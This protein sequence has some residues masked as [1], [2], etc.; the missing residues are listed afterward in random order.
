MISAGCYFLAYLFEA[1]TVYMYFSNKFN[2]KIN[3]K[4]LFLAFSISLTIQYSASFIGN[5]QI[6]LVSFIVCSFLLCFLCYDTK[7]LSSIFNAVI[8]T[9]LMLATELIIM[10]VSMMLFGIEVTEHRTDDLI[11]FAQTGCIKLLFFFVTYI[12]SKL[13]TKESRKTLGHARSM[14][15]LILPVASIMLLLGIVKITELY[16]IHSSVY[17]IFFV[18]TIL[19]IYSNITVFWVHESLIK[20]LHENLEYRLEKQKSTINAEHY[21]ILQ[22]QYESSNILVHD[23]KRHLLSI[24]DFAN[25]KDYDR[26][27]RYIDDLYDGYQIKYL[28]KYSDHKLVNAIV[29]RYAELCR[30]SGLDFFCDIRSVDLS[31]VPDDKL[32][33]IFDNIL[34]NAVDNAKNS[35][36]KKIDLIVNEVNKNFIVITA[37]NSCSQKPV[38]RNG[39]LI[40]TKKQSGLH[41]FGIKSIKRIAKEYNGKVDFDFDDERMIFSITIA[42]MVK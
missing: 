40:S 32:T 14:L 12:V 36:S 39:E 2:R 5:P 26:I 35:V 8:L 25:E 10:F 20:A 24:K 30:L 37:E 1:L 29:T 22:N 16:E 17:Y 6:N 27:I 11:L 3:K 15:L 7:L 42:L 33:S 13:T 31:F 28:R 41:G 9:V 4:F 21:E 18:S 38:K 19:L 23:I 34:E